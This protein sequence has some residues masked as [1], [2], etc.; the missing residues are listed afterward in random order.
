ML[1]GQLQ[2]RTEL[3]ARDFSNKTRP[4]TYVIKRTKHQYQKQLVKAW[5]NK[6]WEK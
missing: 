4:H 5:V 1:P 3:D 2:L 6:D